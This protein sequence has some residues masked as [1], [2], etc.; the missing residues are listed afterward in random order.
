MSWFDDDH[1]PLDSPEMGDREQDH[2]WADLA[3]SEQEFPDS[4]ISVPV[5]IEVEYEDGSCARWQIGQSDP[6]IEQLEQLLGEP[7]TIK[8]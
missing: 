5:L 3:R 2:V 7:D 1:G 6:R 4:P 8:T